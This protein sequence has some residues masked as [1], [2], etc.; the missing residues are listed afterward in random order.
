MRAFLTRRVVRPLRDQLSQ[1]ASP[2]ALARGVTLG[3]LLGIF[4]FLGTTTFLCALAAAA[5]GLNQTA[6][7]T[8]NYAVS[9]LQLL[10]IPVFVRGGEYFFGMA[11]VTLDVR[12][13]P[14]QFLAGPGLFLAQYGRAGLA[15][16]AAWA[17]TAVVAAPAL[18]YLF[19]RGFR[20]MSLRF[21]IR[22]PKTTTPMEKTS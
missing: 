3:A 9:P 4:P 7:Q 2:D 16:A 1:G 5:G 22:N 6:V 12:R 14:E 11:S 21:G 18:L 20:I 17:L 15:G 8:A 13:L 10:L 19:R